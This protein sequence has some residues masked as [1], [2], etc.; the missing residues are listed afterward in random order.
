LLVPIVLGY[1]IF[2]WRAM[3][4]KNITSDEIKSDSH[5]Y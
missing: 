5:K 3:D 2:A 1:I 4:R